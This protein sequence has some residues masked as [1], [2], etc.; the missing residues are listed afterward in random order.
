MV[1]ADVGIAVSGIAGP[2]GGTPQKPVGYTWI[3]L[4][5]AKDSMAANHTFDSDRLGNKDL[6]AETMSTQERNDRSPDPARNP[7]R[8]QLPD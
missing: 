3:G 4:N 7:L 2:G 1:A 6:A 8:E 5:T